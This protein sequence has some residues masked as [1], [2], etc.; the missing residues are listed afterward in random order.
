MELPVRPILVAISLSLAACA[1]A[2]APSP[3]AAEAGSLLLRSTP[4]DGATVRGPV[5]RIDL[6]FARPARLIELMVD[7][8][9]GQSPMMITAAGETVSYSVPTGG[10]GAGSYRVLWRASAANESDEGTIAFTVR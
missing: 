3:V 5:E 6:Q 4:A 10:L 2:P 1:A 7:G 8:P 9:E